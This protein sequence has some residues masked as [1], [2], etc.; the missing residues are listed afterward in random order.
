MSVEFLSKFVSEVSNDDLQLLV[1]MTQGEVKRREYLLG[2]A[3]TQPVRPM[4]G[5]QGCDVNQAR[6]VQWKP[7]PRTDW[8]TLENIDRVMTPQPFRAHQTVSSTIVREALTAAAKAILREVPMGPAKDLA[9]QHII[10]ARMYAN[11]G[12]AFDGE[13]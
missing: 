4:G 6:E 11:T 5:T 3:A 2:K 1:G 12:I 10:E 9:I 8:F 13:L 7:V